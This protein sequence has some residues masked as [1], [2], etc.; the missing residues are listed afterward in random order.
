[1]KAFFDYKTLTMQ[2]WKITPLGN[3][4]KGGV[5]QKIL[6]MRVKKTV[7]KPAQAEA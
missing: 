7:G 4:L 2:V 6:G 5:I 3:V 1:M